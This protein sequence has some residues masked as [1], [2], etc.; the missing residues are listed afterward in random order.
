M[1]ETMD[2]NGEIRP[3]QMGGN[4][5]GVIRDVVELGELQVR[6]LVND[7]KSV[8]RKSIVPLIL[9]VAAASTLLGA[10]P[11]ALL[12]LSEALTTE[13]GLARPLSLLISAIVAVVLAV[14]LYYLGRWR[15]RQ[16]VHQLDSS[17]E[18]LAQ[19]AAWFKQVIGSG[20]TPARST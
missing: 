8:V 18:E 16:S 4:V 1:R 5:A 17:R 15:L 11:I 6:L 19:N 3:A 20:G 13:V 7:T 10:I 9:M 12:A 14:A 2:K